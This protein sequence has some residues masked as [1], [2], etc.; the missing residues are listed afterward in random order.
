MRKGLEATCKHTL[1]RLKARPLCTPESLRA[2]AIDFNCTVEGLTAALSS[3]F[4]VLC[5][6]RLQ[7]IW[8]LGPMVF[9]DACLRQSSFAT[10]RHLLPPRP[11]AC[12]GMFDRC[13]CLVRCQSCQACLWFALVQHL[14]CLFQ[15]W[16]KEVG[17]LAIRFWQ[18]MTWDFKHL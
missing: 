6:E 17:S 9:F 2:T 7:L 12:C 16:E 11:E 13:S 10:T 18:V 3:Q 4:S 1:G 15:R 8:L 5:K 14:P